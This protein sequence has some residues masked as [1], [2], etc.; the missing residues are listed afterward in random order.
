MDNYNIFLYTLNFPTLYCKIRNLFFLTR[1]ST[2]C[3]IF[4][5]EQY[6]ELYFF[7]QAV[8]LYIIKY[9]FSCMGSCIFLHWTT[10]SWKLF[11]LTRWRRRLASDNCSPNQT[12]L[13]EPPSR[14]L[15]AISSI[16]QLPVTVLRIESWRNHKGWGAL[17]S[18]SSLLV[19]VAA[20]VRNEAHN[21][22][23]VQAPLN[24]SY[25]YGN[26]LPL[27]HQRV[28]AILLRCYFY[29]PSSCLFEI[30]SEWPQHLA[31]RYSIC[32]FQM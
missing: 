17:M 7:S 22:M 13:A 2:L 32:S 28:G 8:H 27:P 9:V 10:I 16:H 21:S 4:Q 1:R 6:R 5:L 26:G 30:I 15:K 19:E 3:N 25:C 11:Q 24:I 29:L 12:R 20:C 18:Q 14:V 23:P 31:V